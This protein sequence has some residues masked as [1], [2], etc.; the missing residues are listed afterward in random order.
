[1][2]K[3]KKLQ[4]RQQEQK[5][6]GISRVKYGEKSL[7]RSMARVLEH[8][9]EN[10]KYTSLQELNAILGLYNMEAYRGKEQSQLY[11]HRGLLYRALD[12]HGKYIGVPL[13]A[14]F[15]DCKPTLDN[16]EKK[17][18][19]HQSQKL[20]QKHRMPGYVS[21]NRLLHPHNLRDFDKGLERDRIK[22]VIQRDKQGNCKDVFYVDF[23]SRYIFN[24]QEL[25]EHGNRAT[26]QNLIEKQ[27]TQ[28][29][30]RSLERQQQ[31][32]LEHQ[33]QQ[34]HRRSLDRSLEEELEL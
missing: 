16:L 12:E 21:W 14:S 17:F 33:Q 11:Q 27:K 1:M 26:I 25:G 34:S 24:G 2:T 28:E 15:F 13:K 23:Q 18:A 5:I 3:E 8:I 10:Y 22:M 29:Q 31:Q 19:L 6:D 4:L 20:E 7:A 32:S 9:T 30:Q